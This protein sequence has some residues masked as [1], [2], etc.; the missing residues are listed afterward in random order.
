[1]SNNRPFAERASLGTVVASVGGMAIT[2][3]DKL[4]FPE[5]RITKLEVAQY[6]AAIAPRARPW[7]N[8]RLLTAERCPDGIAG[9]C[10][11]EKNF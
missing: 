8:Q 11:F 7:L 1:M 3:P 10:F 2:H 5:D 9:G 6:Y 4:W